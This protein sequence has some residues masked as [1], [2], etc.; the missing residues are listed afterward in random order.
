MPAKAGIQSLALGP[1]FRGDERKPRAL[2]PRCGR[3]VRRNF[4][5]GACAFPSRAATRCQYIF[6]LLGTC[7]MAGFAPPSSWLSRRR[8]CWRAGRTAP[9]PARLRSGSWDR[10]CSPS[11]SPPGCDAAVSNSARSRPRGTGGTMPLRDRH[12]HIDDA[13]DLHRSGAASA[14]EK[15]P[16]FSRLFCFARHHPPGVFQNS[17]IAYALQMA[18]FGPFFLWGAAGDFWPAVRRQDCATNQ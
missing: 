9:S 12:D 7:S 10:S 15:I 2:S 1:R 16:P 3:P 4:N 14:T 18:T 6:L 8:T 13:C 5:C 11:N 17:A